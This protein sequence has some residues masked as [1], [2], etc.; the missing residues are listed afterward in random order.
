MIGSSRLEGELLM[1]T[2]SSSAVHACWFGNGMFR[3]YGALRRTH[4]TPCLGFYSRMPAESDQL[5][6]ADG[7]RDLA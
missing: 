3:R 7:V 4:V 5:A 2:R 1:R 6:M